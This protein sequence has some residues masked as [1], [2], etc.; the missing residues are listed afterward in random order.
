VIWR[1]LDRHADGGL[2]LARIG[3]GVGFIWYHGWAKLVGGPERWERTGNAMNHIGIDFAPAWWGFAAAVA[4]SVGGL[5]IAVGLFFRP[6]AAALAFVMVIATISH[7]ATG[8]GT[9]AHAFKNAWL[10][11]G[12]VLLGPGRYSLDH[13]LT[14]R[15]VRATAAAAAPSHSK[16]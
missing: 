15:N 8:Q 3:F 10:F 4:E 9:P 13:F 5:F 14:R 16:V 12:L 11:A 7:M 1:A 6:T 2:L